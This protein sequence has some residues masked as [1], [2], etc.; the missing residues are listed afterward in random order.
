[1][2]LLLDNLVSGCPFV[3]LDFY[4]DWCEPCKWVDPILKDVEKHFNGKINILKIDIEQCGDLARSIT[5]LSVPTLI[6]YVDRK[7]VWRM[8]GFD[9]APVLINILS[10][11]IY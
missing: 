7:E 8:R 5:I 1:M 3:L 2:N 10:D 9:S 6:L 4:A 11:F